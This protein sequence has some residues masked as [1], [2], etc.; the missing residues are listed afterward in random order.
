MYALYFIEIHKFGIIKHAWYDNKN[1]Y[2]NLSD[3]KHIFR[4]SLYI[5]NS[6]RT[7]NMCLN[8]KIRWR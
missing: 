2:N 3:K 7:S 5:K 1:N 8:A 4:L 6:D